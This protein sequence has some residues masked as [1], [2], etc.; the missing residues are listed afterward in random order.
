MFRNFNYMPIFDSLLDRWYSFYY[1]EE[2]RSSYGTETASAVMLREEVHYGTVY[3]R[4]TSQ[5]GGMPQ[6]T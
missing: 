4:V 1:E 5:T 2:L 3:D 6:G